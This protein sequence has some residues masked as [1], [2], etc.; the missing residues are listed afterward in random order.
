[1]KIYLPQ[2]FYTGIQNITNSLYYSEAYTAHKNT[3]MRLIAAPG[4]MPE[5]WRVPCTWRVGFLPHS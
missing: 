2:C 1:M 3:Q 5:G 4:R